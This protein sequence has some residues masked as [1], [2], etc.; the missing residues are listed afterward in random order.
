MEAPAGWAACWQLA[1]AVVRGQ[2]ATQRHPPAC[3][4]APCQVVLRGP[5]DL[6]REVLGVGGKRQAPGLQAALLEALERVPQAA[7]AALVYLGSGPGAAAFA[8]GLLHHPAKLCREFCLSVGRTAAEAV[9]RQER[10]VRA[11]G[12]RAQGLRGWLVPCSRL[13]PPCCH[14][15]S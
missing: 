7:T 12:A 4:P 9:T 1:A 11:W 13:V 3:P 5:I 6:R 8:D 14:C 15:P 10:R 2:L